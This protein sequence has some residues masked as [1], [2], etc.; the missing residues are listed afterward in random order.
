MLFT[1]LLKAVT[2]GFSAGITPGPLQ[3]LFLSYAIKG[4]WRKALPAAFAPLMTDAP[5]IFLVLVVLNRLP[6][7]FIRGLQIGGAVFL[8]YL[9]W[10]AFR[11]FRHYQNVDG[12]EVPNGWQTLLKATLANILGPGPW[13]FWS[14][15]NGP[16]LLKAWAISP[17]WGVAYLACFYSA[18]VLTNMVLIMLFATTRQMGDRVRKM[19]LLISVFVLAGFAIYQGL[20]GLMIL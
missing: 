5:V 9:A 1:Y 6:D 3:A 13:L 10:D 16:N 19:L 20:Q 7:G 12:G 15:I 18:F 2:I 8:L 4:G 17:W 14:M 11:S